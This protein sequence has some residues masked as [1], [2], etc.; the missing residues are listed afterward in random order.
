MA[1]AEIKPVPGSSLKLSDTKCGPCHARKKNNQS[2]YWCMSC[3]EGLCE[4]CCDHHKAIK[5]I[6]NHSVVPLL[7]VKPLEQ[8]IPSF[9]TDCSIHDKPLELYCPCHEE[10]CCTKCAS[11]SHPNCIGITLFH[12]FV[13]DLERSDKLTYLDNDIAT[14]LKNIDSLIENRQ[15]NLKE[16]SDQGKTKFDLF[17]VLKEELKDLEIK[18]QSKC[19]GLHV[20]AYAE[21]EA[22]VAKLQKKRQMIIDYK[23]NSSQLRQIGADTQLFHGT[24]QIEKFI[25][26][27]RKSLS[28]IIKEPSMREM[29]IKAQMSD[30]FKQI[31][32]DLIDVTIERDTSKVILKDVEGSLTCQ[33]VKDNQAKVS[34]VQKTMTKFDKSAFMDHA[35]ISCLVGFPGG[36]ILVSDYEGQQLLI[37]DISGSVK[38]KIHFLSRPF[39]LTVVDT[40]TFAVSFP[41]KRN[42]KLY[43]LHTFSELNEIQIG[44]GCWGLQY[45]DDL[46]IAAIRNVEILFLNLSGNIKKAIPM[47]QKN[48]VYVLKSKRSHFRTEF[49]NHSVHCYSSTNGRKQW[50]FSHPSVLGPRNMCFDAEGNLLVACQDSNCVILI[51]SDGEHF[52]RVVEMD[53]AKCIYFDVKKSLLYVCSVNGKEIAAFII[54]KCFG[55]F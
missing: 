34:V 13:S 27:E 22:V 33:S 32:S 23:D 12:S 50:Q 35:N 19:Q 16:I 55:S 51:S 53:C 5:A 46:F 41:E 48:L 52:K 6:R 40:D 1:W 15:V 44:V 3:E 21:I 25:E 4:E 47:K 11:L 36:D 2:L 26:E 54:P 14:L 7:C 9:K 28:E 39:G 45:E 10:P 20:T 30:N 37:F 24:K 18:L 17:V 31:V 42:I 38:K 29:K 49:E 43:F 8:F